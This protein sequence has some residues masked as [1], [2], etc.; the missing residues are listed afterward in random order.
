MIA[1]M[2]KWTALFC[3]V[4]VLGG[5]GGW[6]GKEEAPPLPGERLSVLQHQKALEPDESAVAVE[7]PPAWNNQFW[8]Q[9]GGYPNHAMG[10][11]RLPEELNSVW[12]RDIG[13]GKDKGLSL[14][15]QPIVTDGR[16][17]A[18]D[19]AA[20]LGAYDAETGKELWRRDINP[21]GEEEET[22]GGGVAF[23][24]GR[25]FVSAGY[26]DILAL[27]P[28]TGEKIWRK[29]VP[30]PVRAAPTALNDRVYV[31]TIDNQIFTLSAVDGTI[32][33]RHAGLTGGAG[34]VRAASPAAAQDLVVAP[35]SSAELY[36]LRV[37]NGRV[38]WVDNLA[39]LQRSGGMSSL[40]DI[41][42]LPV[43]DRGLVFAI[44]S[45]G[46]MV[47]IDQRTGM[48]VWQKEIG[49]AE[50]PW[51]AGDV[52]FVL[53]ME[54][55]VAAINRTNG[56]VRWVSQLARFRHPDDRVDPIVWTGPVLAG[57]RLIFAGTTGEVVE[58]SP[59]DGSVIK[60]WKAG[61]GVSVPPVVADGTLYLLN[62]DGRLSAYR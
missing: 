46:R 62:N 17:Y 3:V 25:L 52:L 29:S 41:R 57:G 37:E 58:M 45:G 14:V 36:A 12:R 33:W 11:L 15:A 30:S 60:T 26:A 49:G 50:T 40:A 44:S 24:Q 22:L 9:P 53:T 56:K 43:I 54:N 5:C 27:D 6:L 1:R 39:N 18:L 19:T 32:L 42:G 48:R 55:E 34:I 23:A 28:E 16:I 20:Q 2:I 59:L 4:L 31:T 35:F 10:H 47:A 21:A 38:A 8:P 13:R 51:V 7:I 61:A